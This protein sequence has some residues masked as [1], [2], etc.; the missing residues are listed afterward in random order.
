MASTGLKQIDYII[1]DKNVILENE[2]GK[3]S[4]KV[5]KL[6]K[7]WTVLRKDHNSSPDI[8]IPAIKN[9][10]ITFGSFNNIKKINKKVI[11]IWS[12]ILCSVPNSKLHLISERFNELDFIKYFKRLFFNH[13][14][15]YNN[16]IFE[17]TKNRVDFLNKYN[18]FAYY[19]ISVF[20]MGNKINKIFLNKSILFITSDMPER[21]KNLKN[22]LIIYNK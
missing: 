13:G 12:E 8:T 22:N 5:Y 10:Y 16:L 6:G 7:I 2:E 14:V 17:P 4:E 9:N 3:Y 20:F 21:N 18:Y 19:F 15:D 11:K 1:A